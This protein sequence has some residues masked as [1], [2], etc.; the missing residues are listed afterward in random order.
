M[1]KYCGVVRKESDMKE[2]ILQIKELK[3]ALQYIDVRPDSEGFQDLMLAFDLEGSI[4]SAEATIIPAIQRKESRGAHQRSDYPQTVHEQ[5]LNY[6]IKL[7]SNN[8]LNISKQP[9]AVLENE[10]REIIRNTKAIEN[11]DGMLLE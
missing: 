4:Y 10:L 6:H 5:Q 7:D 1:W 11:F 8:K 2:G 9:I 3:K